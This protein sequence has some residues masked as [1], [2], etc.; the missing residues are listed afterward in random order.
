MPVGMSRRVDH[1]GAAGNREGFAGPQRL[2]AAD[3]FD[4][5]RPGCSHLAQEGQRAGV[6]KGVSEAIALGL[7]PVGMRR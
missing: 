3:A 4:P 6:R 5:Q 7:V 2:R 1:G